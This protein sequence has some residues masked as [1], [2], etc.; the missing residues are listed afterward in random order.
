MGGESGQIS[1]GNGRNSS[2]SLRGGSWQLTFGRKLTSSGAFHTFRF[3][4]VISVIGSG[5]VVTG[6]SGI[7]TGLYPAGLI[8]VHYLLHCI[9]YTQWTN[10]RAGEGL[11]GCRDGVGVG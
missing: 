1:T 3:N 9:F 6:L 10:P 5:I 4:I 8:I 11:R 2:E 7:I